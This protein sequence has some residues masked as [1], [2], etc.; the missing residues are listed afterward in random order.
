MRSI[1]AVLLCGWFFSLNAQAM[2]VLTSIKPIQL[3]TEELTQ[4]VLTPELL[5]PQNASPHDYTLKPSDLKKVQQA[6]LIIWHGGHL[7]GFLSKL[8]ARNP[9]AFA[10]ENAHVHGLIAYGTD[11]SAH[12]EMHEHGT[13]DPHFW[14]G[15]E[16]T[17]GYAKVI[18]NKLVAVDP[19][20]KTK[21]LANLTKF[22]H[23]LIQKHAELIKQLTPVK[24]K[25]F[26]VFHDAF[27]Y[28]SRDYGLNQVGFFTV[29][30][31]RKPGAKTLQSIKKQLIEGK[32]T[33]VFVEPQF[34]PSIIKAITEGTQ[35]KLGSLDPLGSTFE[36]TPGAYFRFLSS[37]GDS[38]TD[39]LQ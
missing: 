5:V 31:D 12:E 13:F 19:A 32:A 37:I 4:G 33:C 22:E 11:K 21:Y 39:C 29:E 10:L 18:A 14:L 24:E 7:E 23:Q 38:L 20:N 1:L 16:P 35:V 30:P 15:F 17:M 36:A 25:G 2:T 34:T 26:F 28:F 3:I 9:K 8:L 27:G 6:D